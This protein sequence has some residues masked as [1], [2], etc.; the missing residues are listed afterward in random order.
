MDSCARAIGTSVSDCQAFETDRAL[1]ATNIDT[2]C[3]SILNYARSRFH[4]THVNETASDVF[5]PLASMIDM[6]GGRCTIWPCRIAAE[7]SSRGGPPLRMMPIRL[8]SCH[9]SRALVPKAFGVGPQETFARRDGC[10]GF[11][12]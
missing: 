10:A 4:M 11:Q 9:A 3:R 2:G 6:V 8:S 12:D 5:D 7:K 1:A